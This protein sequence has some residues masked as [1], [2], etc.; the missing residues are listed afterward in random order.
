[1][2][3]WVQPTLSA[4]AELRIIVYFTDI[5]LLSWISSLFF[6]HLTQCWALSCLLHNVGYKLSSS[7]S[8][9]GWILSSSFR[10]SLA[11]VS[12]SK[13]TN[14]QHCTFLP[15][16]S[17]TFNILMQFHDFQPAFFSHLGA[18]W[19][20]STHNYIQ[21]HINVDFHTWYFFIF[22]IEQISST[23]VRSWTKS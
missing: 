18:Q 5:T 8:R 15:S 21:L 16:I 19:H 6:L 23:V 1:M 14:T 3:T 10:N 4:C 9:W 7:S 11:D 2:Q 22:K 13:A 20:K 12:R 17:T